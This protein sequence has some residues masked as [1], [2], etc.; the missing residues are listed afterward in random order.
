MRP[1]FQDL[2]RRV[3]I[4]RSRNE[5][6][7]S[8]RDTNNT[9]SN[10]NTVTRDAGLTTT[11]RRS[12]APGEDRSPVLRPIS[13]PV[14]IVPLPSLSVPVQHQHLSM[15][16]SPSNSIQVH[17]SPQMAQYVCVVP[18][19]QSLS[20]LVPN[21]SISQSISDNRTRSVVHGSDHHHLRH[22]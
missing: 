7:Y 13:Y 12:L 1:T 16:T 20:S 8:N 14:V 10:N 22:Q 2:N 15:A 17:P 9:N 4:E 6:T 18:P 11:T 19:S 5:S 21:L 3:A